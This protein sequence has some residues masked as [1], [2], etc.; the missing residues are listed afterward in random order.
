MFY[1]NIQV[2]AKLVPQMHPFLRPFGETEFR[3]AD[4]CFYPCM[5]WEVNRVLTE[6][7]VLSITSKACY[8]E[9]HPSKKLEGKLGPEGKAEQI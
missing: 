9:H 3:H 5:L 6:C 1:D 4:V 8:A 7:S 2:S